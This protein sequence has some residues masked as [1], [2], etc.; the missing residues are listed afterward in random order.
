MKKKN[1]NIDKFKHERLPDPEIPADEAWVH[2]EGILDSVPA[3]VK[4]P[5][6]K[7]TFF[8]YRWLFVFTGVL[9]I[10]SAIIFIKNANPSAGEKNLKFERIDTASTSVAELEKKVKKRMDITQPNEPAKS[11]K[12]NPESSKLNLG[13]PDV[14]NQKKAV[15]RTSREVVD[16]IQ[17]VKSKQFEK[18]NKPVKS[19]TT[20]TFRTA[21]KQ[22]HNARNN[23]QSITWLDS[24]KQTEDLRNKDLQN[25]KLVIVREESSKLSLIPKSRSETTAELTAS[26]AIEKSGK[27]TSAET[28]VSPVS[29]LTPISQLSKSHQPVQSRTITKISPFQAK[30]PV[31]KPTSRIQFGPEWGL[32]SSLAQT[33]YLFAGKDSVSRP[34]LLLIPG[35]FVSKSW[36]QHAVSFTF[37]PYQSYF[38]NG[39]IAVHAAD[40]I[41]VNDSLKIY[42]KFYNI[43]RLIK[44]S[45]LNFSMYYHFQATKIF[46]VGGGISYS[47]FTHALVRNEIENYAGMIL[48]GTL[49]SLSKS[50]GLTEAVNPHLFALKGGI[51][52][53]PGRF[54]VGLHVVV[55]VANVSR[56]DQNPLKPLNGQLFIRFNI[57]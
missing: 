46:A 35:I 22:T 5:G 30:V 27:N 55:P 12:I 38:G 13:N 17:K 4:T 29:F 47:F 33:D 3:A 28:K 41:L 10:I 2:M 54:Q 45:G 19:E 15:V 9:T 11:D 24:T 48:P 56:D 18:V 42:S 14:K 50:N 44:T 23:P 52:L 26:Q 7:E 37:S 32:N 16:E 34:A 25:K 57:R 21:K 8:K 49:T 53:T 40:S 51:L 39:K 1:K 6:M 36:Q 43:K 31:R 20:E